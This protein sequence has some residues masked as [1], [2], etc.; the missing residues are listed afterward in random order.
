MCFT[1]DAAYGPTTEAVSQQMDACSQ[2]KVSH[3]QAVL[4]KIFEWMVNSPVCWI[5]LIFSPLE[6]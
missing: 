4:G 5:I 3:K 6:V 2:V 1:I